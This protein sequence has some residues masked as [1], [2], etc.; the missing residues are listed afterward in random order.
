MWAHL[1][2]DPNFYKYMKK[3]AIYADQIPDHIIILSCSTESTEL[4][5]NIRVYIHGMLLLPCICRKIITK[6]LQIAKKDLPLKG[7]SLKNKY[8]L[9]SGVQIPAVQTFLPH[10]HSCD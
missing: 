10:N 9:D 2:I 6:S 5:Q 8:T 7:L 1:L 4:N 3:L